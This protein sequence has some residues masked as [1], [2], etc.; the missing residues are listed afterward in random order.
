[1]VIADPDGR[2]HRL[3]AS[4]AGTLHFTATARAGLYTVRIEQ[5]P[6]RR[7]AVN[8]LDPPESRIAPADNLRLLGREIGDSGEPQP[9]NLELWPL[10][11]FLGLLLACLEW[12]VYNRRAHL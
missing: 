6:P 3:R 5:R 9:T 10:L 12:V 8:L 7:I 4:S 1:V 11:A 2:D